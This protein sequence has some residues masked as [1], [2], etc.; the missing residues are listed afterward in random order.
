MDDNGNGA[1]DSYEFNKAVSDFGIDIEPK[2][3]ANLFRS[4]DYDNSGEVSYDEFVRVIVGPMNHF[5]TQ[6]CVKAFKQ[7]DYNQDG[8]LN[9]DDIKRSY[10]A[11]MHP[12]VKSGKKLE[13]EVLTEFL[14]T[15]EM[16]HSMISD[17]RPDGKVTPEEFIEYYNHV[18]ANIDNDA[19]FELMM[20]NAWQIDSKNNPANMPFAG[21]SRKITN[22]NSRE[23]YRQDH[24]RNLFGTDN[25]TPFNKKSAQANW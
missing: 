1:L 20:A 19:Y 5:R 7:I 14:E 21:S 12:D 13:D 3:L 2:E 8:V 6:I 18:S 23:A 9:L 17:R 22:V 4:F 11:A 10:N 24:H 25:A 16:H 15:F